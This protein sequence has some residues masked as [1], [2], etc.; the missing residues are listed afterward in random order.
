MVSI[1]NIY[2]FSPL[3]MEVVQG[4]NIYEYDDIPYDQKLIILK[5]IVDSLN[6]IHSLGFVES[7]QDS[8]YQAYIGKTIER[9]EKIRDLV[10]FANDETIKINGRTCRNV[11]YHWEEINEEINKYFPNKFVFIHGDCTFSNILLNNNIKPVLIDPRGYFGKTEF[12]GDEAYDWV[13]LYYSLISNYDQFNLKRFSLDIGIHEIFLQIESNHWED[14]EEDFFKLLDG[15]V[16]RKQMKLLLSITWLSLTT[17]AW[18]DYDSICG[19]FYQGILYLEDAFHMSDPGT[20]D[21]YFGETLRI[22][23]NSLKN[24]DMNQFEMLIK[25]SEKTLCRGHKIIASG[26]GKNV[27]VC[28]KFVGSMLSLGLDA[29]FLHTNTAVHGDLGMVK[30]G[31]L[32]IV[33]SKSGNTSESV[34]FVELLKKRDVNIILLTFTLNS[35]CEKIVGRSNCI[36]VDMEHEGDMWNIMPNNSTTL[37]LII[38]QGLVMT[39][40]ERMH[41]DLQRD[42]APN[43]PGGAI[44]KELFYE[45]RT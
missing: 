25:L 4:K 42:F 18:E 14:M 37:N 23:N 10:P 41:L 45:E 20:G 6:H 34:Y 19:A 40:A 38:L 39:L 27:P 24:L 33:L 12:F 44:G 1:P 21:K 15:K 9:L 5:K 17:Y 43:H 32:V 16:T 7:D 28:E 8:F 13:K 2:E 11:F 3:T 22:L 35:R 36:I 29:N 31:D 30:D 26:L